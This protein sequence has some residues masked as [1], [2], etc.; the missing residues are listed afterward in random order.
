MII[1][2][3]NDC[4]PN[5]RNIEEYSLALHNTILAYKEL[6]KKHEI[7][8]VASDNQ[9][10]LQLAPLITLKLC[11]LDIKN[12][13]ERTYALRM[14]NKY[15]IGKFCDDSQATEWLLNENFK[16]SIDGSNKDAINLAL[17]AYSNGMLFSLGLCDDLRSNKLNLSGEKEDCEIYNLYGEYSNTEYID[18]ELN[19]INESGKS[20][21][22][23]IKEEIGGDVHVRE[24]FIEDFNRIIP[25]KQKSILDKFSQ[26]SKYKKL[27]PIYVDNKNIKDVTPTNGKKGP[28]YELRIFSPCVLRVYFTQKEQIFILIDIGD[29]NDQD[30]DINRAYNRL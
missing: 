16:I 22:E 11:I 18:E 3:F 21:L 28:M 12:K 17:T 29:K 7:C 30:S 14:F 6:S 10:C 24:T 20:L 8:V 4:L 26:V 27:H 5:N 1:F 9:D 23:K 19:S 2:F 13:E 15:P 25:Y